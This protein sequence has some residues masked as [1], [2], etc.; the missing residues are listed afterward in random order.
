[1]GQEVRLM[2][3]CPPLASPIPLQ[4][5]LEPGSGNWIELRVG[6]CPVVTSIQ[7]MGCALECIGLRSASFAWNLAEL[8]GCPEKYLRSLCFAE[9]YW[10]RRSTCSTERLGYLP[11]QAQPQGS[12]SGLGVE[13]LPFDKGSPQ[14]GQ[15]VPKPT[16]LPPTSS[17]CNSLAL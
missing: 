7:S 10:A 17:L 13:D 6:N 12:R 5:W 11:P 1:M 8:A 14:W 9:P 16:E 2:G 3:F 4:W 15:E